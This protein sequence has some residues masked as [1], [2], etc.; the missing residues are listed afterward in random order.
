MDVCLFL[1]ILA[2]AYFW[3][4]LA[5]VAGVVTQPF[6]GWCAAGSA[7]AEPFQMFTLLSGYQK[8]L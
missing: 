5:W 1:V 6:V 7:G 3:L 2:I 4:D 8:R